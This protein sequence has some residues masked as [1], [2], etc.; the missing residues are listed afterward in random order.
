MTDATVFLLPVGSQQ[1]PTTIIVKTTV[2]S[3]STT[4]SYRYVCWP[5]Q[6]DMAASL[7]GV[8]SRLEAT[9][10]KE[11]GATRRVPAPTDTLVP[12]PVSLFA[13]P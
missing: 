9:I 13:T 2:A 4:T 11:G 6:A 12:H 3:T 7:G 5:P 10:R 8:S 1:Q